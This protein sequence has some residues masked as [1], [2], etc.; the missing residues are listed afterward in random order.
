MALPEVVTPRL[1]VR[2][3]V[4]ADDLE[5]FHRIW[6]DSEVIWWGAMADL[7]AS[8]ELIERVVD[9]GRGLGWGAVVVRG[10]G[11]I[12]GNAALMP[13]PDGRSDIEVGWHLARAHWGMGYATEAA[14]ALVD[15]AFTALALS[16][17]VADIVPDNDRSRAVATRLGMRPEE[18]VMRAGRVHDVWVRR[19][20]TTT[21]PD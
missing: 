13:T 7:G 15:H 5:A 3:W 11:Q 12:V 17:V 16:R 4:V 10:T 19:R 2:P 6:G 18:T 8:R 1:C 21:G 9:L 20:E 14:G